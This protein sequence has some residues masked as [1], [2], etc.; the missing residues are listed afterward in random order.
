L[1][2]GRPEYQREMQTVESWIIWILVLF[3]GGGHQSG[4]RL[5]SILAIFM[6]IN[7]TAFYLGPENMCEAELKG[8]RSPSDGGAC[9]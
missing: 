5:E 2:V 9:P 6:Q 3:F 7:L 4:A 1:E 8:D